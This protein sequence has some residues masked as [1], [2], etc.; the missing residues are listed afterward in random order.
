M[1]QGREATDRLPSEKTSELKR[2]QI[3]LV[4]MTFMA[5]SH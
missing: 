5:I 4:D 1:G 2:E 3:F